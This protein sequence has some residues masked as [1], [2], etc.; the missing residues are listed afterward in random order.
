VAG[1]PVGVVK[2]HQSRKIGIGEHRE[3]Y[4]HAA[5]EQPA[6]TIKQ[7]QHE[8]A[9]ECIFGQDITIPDQGEMDQAECQQRQ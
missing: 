2:R 9:G 3:Q 5:G 1:Q 8:Q 7:R 6:R 4:Q